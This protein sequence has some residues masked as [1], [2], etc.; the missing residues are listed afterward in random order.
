MLGRMQLIAMGS[1]QNH[2]EKLEVLVVL[3]SAVGVR[4][5]SQIDRV[6]HSS[7]FY[8]DF[9]YATFPARSIIMA[10]TDLVASRANYLHEAAHLLAASSPAASAFFGSARNRLAQDSEIELSAKELDALRRETCGACGCLM[11]PGWSC[12]ISNKPQVRKAA[13]KKI[14]LSDIAV[15]NTSTVYH[16]LRCHRKTEHLLQPQPRRP[17]KKSTRFEATQP[18]TNITKSITEGDLKTPK[19][20]NASSKQRQ[21][22]RKGG[23]QAM[24]E[25]NKSQSSSQGLDLMDFA[26]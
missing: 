23:L 19:T 2:E 8:I 22:A 14:K 10:M 9:L 25:K 13:D 17:L 6:K 4:S 20:A 21:K 18:K 3:A 5:C 16:C 26:M 24:L 15:E 12:K 11:V 1:L 7:T